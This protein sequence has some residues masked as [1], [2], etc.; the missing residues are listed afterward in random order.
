MDKHQMKDIRGIDLSSN[1]QPFK[2]FPFNVV[3]YGRIVCKIERYWPIFKIGPFHTP[4]FLS[5]WVL[6]I[7]KCDKYFE[8]EKW[9]NQA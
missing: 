5:E 8:C 2:S 1:N 3:V 6:K 4:L 7:D 9:G